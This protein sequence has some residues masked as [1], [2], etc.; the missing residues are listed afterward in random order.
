M[1]SKVDVDGNGSSDQSIKSGGCSGNS[2]RCAE[3]PGGGRRDKKKRSRMD[4]AVSALLE[5]NKNT[6]S[7]TDQLPHCCPASAA[8][9]AG[10]TWIAQA[11][12][13]QPEAP[14][15]AT[16][17][18]SAHLDASQQLQLV[19]A[20]SNPAQLPPPQWSYSTSLGPLGCFQQLQLVSAASNPAQLPP[21]H[22]LPHP[23]NPMMHPA[24]MNPWMISSTAP[25]GATPHSSAHLDASQQLQLASAASNPAHLP[26]YH[27]L[28]YPMNPMMHPG[29][30]NPWMM[31]PSG[32]PAAASAMAAPMT[33]GCSAAT[34]SPAPVRMEKECQPHATVS[35]D[36][37]LKASA[38]PIDPLPSLGVQKWTTDQVAQWLRG[39]GCEDLVDPC[40]SQDV[41]G[42]AL[43]AMSEFPDARSGQRL[44]LVEGLVSLFTRSPMQT[45]ATTDHL[46]S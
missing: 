7:S 29:F 20:A 45:P 40:S 31:P 46:V 28:P 5:L 6:P 24:F 21:Y 25:N 30:M 34:S 8:L 27:M 32:M 41:D 15:G 42:M 22:M 43:K 16:P 36:A 38:L 12:P 13:S 18:P 37:A 9:P 4:G 17:H 35:E 23:M 19:S 10:S 2:G 44:R 39:I 26:P 14:I 33:R 1:A 3:N 11:S